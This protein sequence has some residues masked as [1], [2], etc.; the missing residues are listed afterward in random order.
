MGVGTGF[1]RGL[2]HFSV[3]HRLHVGRRGPKNVPDPLGS[4]R[5]GP[6]DDRLERRLEVVE[7]LARSLP[8]PVRSRRPRMID[9]T[10][11]GVADGSA[12]S[13]SNGD[14]AGD[15]RSVPDGSGRLPVERPEEPVVR[16][17][18]GGDE[19]VPEVAVRYLDSA[20]EFSTADFA[21]DILVI[22]F[23]ASW[24]LACRDEHEALVRA[25]SDY[26]DFGTTFVAVNY[27]DQP[28]RAAEI[29]DSCIRFN[30]RGSDGHET[31]SFEPESSGC[32]KTAHKPYDLAVC[33]VLLALK[34]H[35]SSME[36]TSDGFAANLADQKSV[37]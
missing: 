26:A 4:L 34:A 19:P 7:H 1:P 3:R 6:S 29:T 18:H 22:N 12:G 25:A 23:W 28:D 30:G 24:C 36:L 35:L 31:F 32:C 11:P 10:D 5:L 13:P 27:Q 37:P 9:L 15:T 17:P 14:A 8:D 21:G 2:A 20:D 16:G 33:E